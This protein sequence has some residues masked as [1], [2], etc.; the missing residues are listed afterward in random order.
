MS[1]NHLIRFL[2]ND[3]LGGG[4]KNL[5]FSPLLGEDFQ[6]DDHIFQDGLVQPPTRMFSILN[7]SMYFVGNFPQKMQRKTPSTH[8]F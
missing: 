3:Q 6:F 4:F 2:K 7:M 8:E 5:L 1:F